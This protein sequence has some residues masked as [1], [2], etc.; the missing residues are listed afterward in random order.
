MS[1]MFWVSNS[2]TIEFQ[3]CKRKYYYSYIL[4]LQPKY[5]SIPLVKGNFGHD[6]LD[7][8]YTAKMLADDEVG[9]IDAVKENFLRTYNGAADPE[10]SNAYL[11]TYDIVRRYLA[12][13][14]PFHNPVEVETT[15]K[16]PLSGRVGIAFKIDLLDD[17]DGVRTLVDHK[18]TSRAFTQ[19]KIA[20]TA[21]LFKY[22]AALDL[23]DQ[24][25]DRVVINQIM[26]Q[27]NAPWPH[28]ALDM[29]ID[30]ITARMY[31]IEHT[32]TAEVIERWH[33]DLDDNEVENLATRCFN[34]L[35]CQYCPFFSLC[36]NDLTLQRPREDI[37]DEEF[38]PNTYGYRDE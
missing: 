5:P 22:M 31:L 8:Y 17:T 35:V 9:P 26:F 37:I 6:L 27:R 10:I 15:H 3:S 12:N 33:N 1:E 20:T 38:E 14:N 13:H 36:Q 19:K 4:R 2:E 18:F 16:V 7:T 24:P 32:K 21:Q 23:D 29:D 28:Q 25:V 30:I 34:W 11:E